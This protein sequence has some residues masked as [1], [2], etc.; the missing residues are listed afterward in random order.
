MG[1]N[2]VTQVLAHWTHVSDRAFRVLTRMAV[3]ALDKP[4]DGKPA[5]IYHGGRELLA[6]SL[7]SGK[8]SMDTRYRS[9]KRAVAELS[10]AGA[11]QHLRSGWAGQNAVYRLTLGG[12]QA[13][14]ADDSDPDEMGGLIDPP[15]G[16][17]S[18]PPKGG[19]VN[20]NEGGLSSPPKEHEDEILELAEE[21]VGLSKT[22][23]HP[24]RVA[25]PG[26][27]AP[28]IPLFPGTAN[29]PDEPPYRSPPVI[30]RWRNRPDPTAEASARRRK[31]EAE[32]QA[33]LAEET[34]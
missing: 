6:M 20:V 16:G 1:A 29:A 30:S 23:S 15:V 26:E 8:G 18:D 14:N 31:A 4:K 2:L 19:P 32:Y 25:A 5:N 13:A 9:V 17:F 22:A 27:P 7:R 24:P 33:R 34:S 11:I 3:T 28:V 10:E 21:K 12:T